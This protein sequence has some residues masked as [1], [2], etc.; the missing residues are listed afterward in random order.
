M[1]GLGDLRSTAGDLRSSTGDLRSPAINPIM[2]RVFF[3]KGGGFQREFK[4]RQGSRCYIRTRLLLIPTTPSVPRSSQRPH[5]VV[6]RESGQN[7]LKSPVA[8][9]R[10]F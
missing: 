7:P 5:T 2:E 6:R 10:T 1:D 9:E 8:A 4:G 3:A